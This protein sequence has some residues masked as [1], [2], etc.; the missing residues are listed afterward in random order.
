MNADELEEHVIVTKAKPKSSIRQKGKKE[1]DKSNDR[2]I[3]RWTAHLFVHLAAFFSFSPPCPVLTALHLR[4]M[5]SAPSVDMERCTSTPCSSGP[6]TKVPPS[7]TSVSNAR[8]SYLHLHHHYLHH[9]TCPVAT[10]ICNRRPSLAHV[11]LI[12][13]FFFFPLPP[14]TS[15]LKTTELHAWREA[16]LTLPSRLSFFAPLRLLSVRDPPFYKLGLIYFTCS[17]LG[18]VCVLS[19][20]QQGTRACGDSPSLDDD[21]DD[22]GADNDHPL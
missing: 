10:D 20:S 3:V 21:D 18:G 4:S 9:H 13:S 5:K 7:S 15:S 1:E 8:T 17:T 14:D 22:A 12:S 19:T 16:L 11:G 6:S 2:A